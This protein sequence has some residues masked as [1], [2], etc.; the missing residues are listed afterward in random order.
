MYRPLFIYLQAFFAVGRHSD[1][2]T[3]YFDR[4]AKTWRS[5]T[6]FPQL[7]PKDCKTS[8]DTCCNAGGNLFVA[9]GTQ[10]LPQKLRHPQ[11]LKLDVINKRWIALAPMIKRRQNCKLVFL[12]D[13]IYA[14]GGHVISEVYCIKHNFWKLL[15]EMPVRISVGRM[16][17]TPYKGKILVYGSRGMAIDDD[18]DTSESSSSDSDE[19]EEY[20]RKHHLLLM[21]D[22]LSKT[23]STLMSA[24]HYKSNTI[25]LVVQDKKVYRIIAGDCWCK[26]KGCQWHKNHVHELY[27]TIP[28][29]SALVG[30]RLESVNALGKQIVSICGKPYIIFRRSIY[31]LSGVEGLYS[32]GGMKQLE[33][34]DYVTMG[35]VTIFMFDT[36]D[37]L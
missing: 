30:E 32:N 3:K 6:K 15:P 20:R 26:K 13:K 8:F 36:T 5:L 1:E 34:L 2:S 27:V 4:K 25:G 35:L 21:F 31:A 22:P 16:C 37:F 28:D 12:D 29:Q 10:R 33:K 24:Y 9:R 18:P 11:F 7:P 19:E 23:W 17:C 14:I